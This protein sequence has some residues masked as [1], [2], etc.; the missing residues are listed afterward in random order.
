MNKTL[1]T[2][3]TLGVLVLPVGAVAAQDSSPDV[4]D[5]TTT[6][7]TVVDEPTCGEQQRDRV[8]DQTG[9]RAD[10]PQQTRARAQSR[11]EDCDAECDGSNRRADAPAAAGEGQQMR[12]RKQM[13]AEDGAAGPAAGAGRRV[14]AQAGGR[15][16]R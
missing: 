9:D 6:T 11:S 3:T 4:D 2:L 5:A 10:A 12:Q 13:F 16:G 14:Q 1:L 15:N 8:R 7:T